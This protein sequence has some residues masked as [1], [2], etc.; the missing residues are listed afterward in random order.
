MSG[1]TMQ[2]VT[3]WSFFLLLFHSYFV[4]DLLMIAI[5]LETTGLFTTNDIALFLR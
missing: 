4:G 5:T 3:Y 1:V 2:V